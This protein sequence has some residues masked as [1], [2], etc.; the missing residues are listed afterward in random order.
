MTQRLLHSKQWSKRAALRP[1]RAAPSS[2]AVRWHADADRVTPDRILELSYAFWKSKAV[3]SA[4]EL[5]LFTVGVAGPW[6]GR[7]LPRG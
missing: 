3:L 4:V 1:R 7:R 5:D 2:A 6:T